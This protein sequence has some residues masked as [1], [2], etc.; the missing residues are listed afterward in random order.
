MLIN[1]ALNT[2]LEILYFVFSDVSIPQMPSGLLGVVETIKNIVIQGMP[3]V[4][5]FL[6]KDITELCLSVALPLMY[7]EKIYEFVM[8]VVKKLPVSIE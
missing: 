8:W 7:F 5:M 3:I 2:L 4:W 1:E 6:D